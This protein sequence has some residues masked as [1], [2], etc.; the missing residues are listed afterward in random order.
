MPG[1]KALTPDQI[2]LAVAMRAAGYSVPAIAE[3]L[4][5]SP[6]TI[7]R[8][9]ERHAAKKG[10]VMD[11]LIEQAKRE[12]VD[13]IT[14]VERIKEEAARM[15]ADDLAHVRLLR[16]RVAAAYELLHPTN[17]QEAA[18]C[19]RA[20]AAAATTLKVTSDTLRRSLRTDRA[21]DAEE[22]VDLPELVVVE[23]TDEEALRMREERAADM[24]LPSPAPAALNAV[25]EPCKGR[26]ESGGRVTKGDD[27]P[28][29][30]A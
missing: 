16:E 17:L 25:D 23:I 13:S 6:R 11:K 21:L 26:W 28:P 2:A 18:V 29:D 9:F 1:K 8:V 19:L 22:A 24:A 12:L 30:T 4:G 20:A 10:A 5:V 3:R 27:E 14:G 7:N 15:V